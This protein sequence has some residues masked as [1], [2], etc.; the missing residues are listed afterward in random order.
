MYKFLNLGFVIC[1]LYLTLM[2]FLSL[3]VEKLFGV[4]FAIKTPLVS[5]L[6]CYFLLKMI[7]VVEIPEC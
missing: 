1:E 3:T 4:L 6:L 2:L 7:I 5:P